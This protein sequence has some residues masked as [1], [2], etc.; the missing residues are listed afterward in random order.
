MNQHILARHR[1]R[2]PSNT[3]RHRL[4]RRLK[5]R[6]DSTLPVRTLRR[7]STPVCTNSRPWW[8][9]RTCSTCSALAPRTHQ[10]HSG[11]A[12][13]PPWHTARGRF[14]PAGR[15]SAPAA[16]CPGWRHGTAKRNPSSAPRSH[17]GP[18]PS[19]AWASA[20]S[21]SSSWQSIL[22]SSSRN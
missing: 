20:D 21:W 4:A 3:P 6:R 12:V 22:A 2:L 5:D 10:P 7:H 8:P 9:S 15:S 16:P 11:T 14:H 1:G 18:P 19:P 13:A 17:L